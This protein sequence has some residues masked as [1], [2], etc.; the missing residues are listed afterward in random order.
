VTV[1]SVRVEL[2]GRAYDVV[3]GAGL[4]AEA[5]ARLA[6]LAPRG[7]VAIV[8]DAHVEAALGDRLR[9][10]LGGLRAHWLVLP[11][12]EATKSL[13][14]FARAVSWLL[15]LGFDRDEPVIAFGGGVVGDLA[16]FAAAATK[17]GLPL[18]QLPTTLLA[19]V[20]SSVGGKT[21]VNAPQ[22]KNL[23]G[24]FHQPRLVL[25][26]LDALDT[27]PRRE[28]LSGYAEVV[29]HALLGDAAFFERLERDGPALRAGDRAARLHAVRRSVEMKAAIVA[30]DERESGERALLNL[31]H[32]FAHALETATGYSDRLRH[33]EAVALGLG[34]AFDLSARVGACPAEAP[35]RVRAHLAEMGLPT[36]LADLP[37]DWP[38]ADALLGLMARDKKAQGGRIVF[39]LARGI[40]R[41]FVARDV[42]PQAARAVLAEALAER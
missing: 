37:G 25:A 23:I 15:D 38:D 22:G 18:A 28:L 6:P 27:L 19:Q 34:L 10:G 16:G 36:R 3:A 21:G 31:G 12:G 4:L 17:R 13:D 40:G 24:A 35:A 33:G 11:P 8:T 5:G 20:D 14:Q 42:E 30:R 1:E 2:G 41:A 7:R 39:V 9:E 29:K 26:D 32:T